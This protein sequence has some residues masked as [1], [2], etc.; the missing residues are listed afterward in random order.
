MR[1]LLNPKWLF[2]LNTLP[3]AVL[4]LLLG[5]VF[6]V[7]K[8][9]LPPESLQMW[10]W[11]WAA[12]LLLTALPAGYAAWGLW[13]G[14]P[15]PWLY[16]AVLLLLS[17]GFMFAYF[18]LMVEAL[19]PP[20][21][22]RWM[23]GSETDL[24]AFTFLMPTAVHALLVLVVHSLPAGRLTWALP[25]FGLALLVPLGAFVVGEVL[26]AL[27]SG[28]FR[29]LHEWLYLIPVGLLVAIGPL[30]F[31]FFLARGLV[32]VVSSRAGSWQRHQ[33]IWKILVA[34]V[35]PLLGLAL[36]GGH[37][38]EWLGGRSWGFGGLFGDFSSP[39]F[40]G[41][42]VVNCGLLCLPAPAGRGARLALLA[43]RCAT[44][45]YTLYFCVVFLPWLPLSVLAIIVLGLGFLLLAP[46][47][48]FI[49]HL[50]QLSEDVA[51]LRGR[52][53]RGVVAAAMTAGL[54]VLPL[55]LTL[56]YL[57]YRRTLHAA[58]AY[59]YT[60]DYARQ[61]HIDAEALRETLG[62]VRAYKSR[63]WEPMGSGGQPYLSRYFTWLVLDNLTLSD[64]KLARLEQIFDGA[65]PT[66]ASPA[67]QT[68]AGITQ[69]PAAQL[70][71]L[72]HRSRY[73]ARQA[74][75]VSWVDLEVTGNP[76]GAGGWTSR[77]YA[78]EF[79]LPPGCWVQD[80]YLDIAGRREH[81]ILAEKKAAAWVFAQIE[82]E[83]RDPGI[84]HYLTG[85]RL[86]LRVFPVTPGQVRRTGICFVHKEPVSL[87]FD[88]QPVQL[89]DSTR[90]ATG[91]TATPGREVVYLSRAAKRRLP[92]LRRRPYYHF[93]LD[94]SVGQEAHKA[95]YLRWIQAQ[96]QRL[97]LPAPA[98]FTLV[99]SYAQPVSAGA[100]WQQQLRAAPTEGG[101]YAAG[102][103]RRI[104]AEQ[105]QEPEATYPVLVLVSAAAR[106]AVLD[107]DFADLAA[108]HPE[109]PAFYVL[110]PGARLEARAL[111]ASPAQPWPTAPAPDSV[112]A[113]R[114]W[115]SAARPRAFLPDDDQPA[116]VLNAAQVSIPAAE[117]SDALPA[118]PTGLLLAGY[119]QHLAL[120]PAQ[121]EAT[122]LSA[123]RASF[124]SGILTPL[125]SYLSLENEAQKAALRRKQAEVLRANAALDA[126][127]DTPPTA[128]PLD[129]GASLLLLAGGA[130]ALRQL[131]RRK[132]AQPA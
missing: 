105:Q 9:L 46:L 5:G 60:P 99:G 43:A 51:S 6:G 31:L 7:I 98:R 30:T 58:L 128:V 124:R 110:G 93:L 109:S 52:F 47:L 37:L 4:L 40:Y 130:L 90:A 122:R 19:F 119:D 81:G 97:P 91:E 69:T 55:G 83:N 57:H 106:R 89:G 29:G 104:L 66:D 38:P 16:G 61:Y 111:D 102:A 88:G 14:R 116:V 132:A 95:D 76:A 27:P 112:A 10:R 125:T 77:E 117:A 129:G 44:F 22:P 63:R 126:G 121:A 114:A 74:A 71:R 56:H 42:T 101:F 11:L 67:D 64:G 131:R 13:R 92:L 50:N 75:W 36:N 54:L 72:G 86:G 35:L 32:I 49:V 84:L 87:R 34:G 18:S 17:T 94:V 53:P 103:M 21:V 45:G 39:W 113:V 108:A 115:P 2:V 59:V 23:L 78:T 28:L 48:L 70:T 118:W 1:N 12:L 96:Q 25:N 65:A 80:Y 107:A 41:L 3:V 68:S 123:I 120:N 73:D 100:D 15:L 85:R 26:A 82:N 20:V 33:E 8:P 24:Y 79:S 127:E 62:V